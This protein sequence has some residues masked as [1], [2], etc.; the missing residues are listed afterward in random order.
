[1]Y[2]LGIIGLLTHFHFLVLSHLVL[3]CALCTRI[4]TQP[5]PEKCLSS[6]NILFMTCSNFIHKSCCTCVLLEPIVTG[7]AKL[8]SG[9]MW[10][11]VTTATSSRHP[12]SRRS[13]SGRISRVSTEFMKWFPGNKNIHM[14]NQV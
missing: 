3:F 9:W 12:G 10:E 5:Y 1:M 6:V 11:T 14:I 7:A 13:S 4:L 8:R 2:I